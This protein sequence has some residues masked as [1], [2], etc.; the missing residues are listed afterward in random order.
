MNTVRIEILCY[1]NYTSFELSALSLI[2]YIMTRHWRSCHPMGKND[3]CEKLLS[4]V[5]QNPNKK[6]ENFWLGMPLND[7]KLRSTEFHFA[8]CSQRKSVLRVIKGAVA[9]GG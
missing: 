9:Q 5:L 1:L 8:A 7:R 4:S 6:C 3:K 2:Y